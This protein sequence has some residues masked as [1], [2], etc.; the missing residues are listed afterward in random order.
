[1]KNLLLAICISGALSAVSAAPALAANLSRAGEY[2]LCQADACQTSCRTNADACRAQC[3]DPE[4]EKQCIVACGK[5][6]CKAMCDK[7]ENNC[8]LHCPSSGG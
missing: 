3:S 5:G 1:M 6:E 7:F 2:K 8:K 4:E